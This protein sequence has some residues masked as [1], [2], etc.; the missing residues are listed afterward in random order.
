VEGG[1]E[2]VAGAAE[3]T[4]DGG[5]LEARVNAGEENDEVFDGEIRDELVVRG[6]EL[7]FGGFPGGE[8]CPI[9][10]VASLEG[11]FLIAERPRLDVD[12]HVILGA[13]AAH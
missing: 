4:A 13:R 9:H 5:C 10:R 12:Y 7:G 11:I 2:T 3:V 8:Q 6:E 1:P